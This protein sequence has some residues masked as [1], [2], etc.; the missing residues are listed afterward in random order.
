MKK[1]ERRRDGDEKE[2]VEGRSKMKRVHYKQ[3]ESNVGV[4]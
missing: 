2:K 3:K 1:T 4:L